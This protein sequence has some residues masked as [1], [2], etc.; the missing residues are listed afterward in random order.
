MFAFSS[1]VPQRR[2]A[3]AWFACLLLTLTL[4][5]PFPGAAAATTL[6]SGTVTLD[7]KPAIGITVTAIGNNTTAHAISDTR[8]RFR[9]STLDTGTYLLQARSDAAQA[10]LRLDLPSG[11]AN[12]FL[13]LVPKVIGNVVVTR[14]NPLITHGSGTDLILNQQQIA[15]MPSAKSIPS[16]LIQLPGAARG[17]NGV[18]HIN[19]DHGDIN[20]IVDGVVVPQALNRIVGS[21]LDSNDIAFTEVLQGAYPAQ[22]GGRFA[23]I[24]NI[25]TSTGTGPAGFTGSIEAGSYATLDSSIGYHTPLGRGSLV[26]A[27]RNQRTDRALDPPNFDSP[28]NQGSDANQFLRYTLPNG[29]DSFNFTFS[30]SFQTFQI[31][32]DVA[33]GEPANTDDNEWQDDVFVA[34]QY[35]HA[36]GNRGAVSFGSGFKRSQIRDFGDPTNDF[37]YGEA[38]NVQ[39]PPFGNGGSPDDCANAVTTGNFSP[40]T[41]G[42]S[43]SSDK[44]SFDYLFNV[45]YVRQLGAHEIRS[46]TYYDAGNV[47]KNYAVTL[48]PGNFLAPILTPNT[49]DA[50]TAVTDNAPNSGATEALYLQDSWKMGNTYE[51]DYGLREDAFQLSS[52]GEFAVGYSQLSPRVKFQRIF[53]PRSNVYVYYGRFFTPFS[54]ENL[55]PSAA[56]VLNLPLQ[57]S[58]AAFDLKPQRDSDYEIG[59]HLPVGHGDLGWR[60]MQKNATDLIDDTQVGVTNLHQDINYRLGRIATQSL[61]YQI[62]LR[63][64]GRFY[65]SANHTYSKNKGCETQLLAPCYG[66]PT[67]WTPADHEQVWGATMGLLLN[68]HHGGWFSLDGEYGSGLPTDACPEDASGFCYATPHIVFDA[69]KGFGIGPKT[70]L[71][72]R[73][74]NLLNDRYYVT[75]LNAQGTHDAAPREI[76]AGVRFGQP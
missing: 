8:G 9:F 46:G 1:A 55:S 16:M 15:H 70:A 59:G 21:E 69:E 11:G 36:I 54:F 52:T 17:A 64:N 25:G 42:Y 12:V 14:A 51:L 48:Q 44:T 27:F 4:L 63:D 3:C 32:N 2:F 40:T 35:H 38:L 19:G 7:G 76:F 5:A 26:M 29:N 28:H 39:P 22:Y 67:D 58:V 57:Q 33:H 56:Q 53:S 65:V 75:L 62:P 47:K 34:A 23:S 20:Y 45:D 73:I 60:V 71:T 18:V 24:L 10:L 68:D 74:S 61:Y 41:C 13:T 30:H 50:P 49:S 37:A 66:S 43:L 6:L 31:P 72:L